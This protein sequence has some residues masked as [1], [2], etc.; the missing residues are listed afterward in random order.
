M[1]TFIEL[2][3]SRFVWRKGDRRTGGQPR[4]PVGDEGVELARRASTRL[5]RPMRSASAAPMM[6]AKKRELLG[7]VQADPARQQPRTAEV[8]AE[9]A[10][11]ED[12]RE[13]RVSAG[14]HEV[15]AERQVAAGAHRDAAH[16]GDGGLRQSVQRERHVADVTHRRPTDGAVR[17]AV[18]A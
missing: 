4:R 1:V 15:A 10:A 7:L 16:L 12:L 18:R 13:A 17:P 9:A 3:S 8:Q 6:S 5:T 2:F 11:G 14:H